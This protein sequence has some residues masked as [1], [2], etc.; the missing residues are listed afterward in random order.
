MHLVLACCRGLSARRR[1]HCAAC[2]HSGAA[3]DRPFAARRSLARLDDVVRARAATASDRPQRA[4][5]AQHLR[6]VSVVLHPAMVVGICVHVCCRAAFLNLGV[7]ERCAGAREGRGRAERLRP[8]AGKPQRSRLGYLSCRPAACIAVRSAAVWRA[9]WV[10]G[11]VPRSHCRAW[12]PAAA[13]AAAATTS[14][15]CCC[16]SCCSCC[17]RRRWRRW[18][19]GD[20][21]GSKCTCAWRATSSAAAAAT[22]PSPP[23]APCA[24]SRC[25]SKFGTTSST[26]STAGSC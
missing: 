1:H 2:N 3:N 22:P 24:S 17:R 12:P 6:P 23:T 14:T 13:A 18:R 7:R 4:H 9:C 25:W 21:S 16:C 19:Q 8:E 10:A 15:G 26:A 20:F 11:K 5:A